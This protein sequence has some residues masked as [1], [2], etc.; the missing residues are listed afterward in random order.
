MFLQRYQK[1]LSKRDASGSVVFDDPAGKSPGGYE[2]RTLLLRQ[3]NSLK[4][5]GCPYTN[6]TFSNVGPITFSDSKATTFI[7]IADLIAYNTFRQ[8]RTHGKEWEDLT[9][10]AFPMY[11]H[12]RSVVH[13]FDLGPRRRLDGF[14]IAKWPVGN[15]VA[16]LL[17]TV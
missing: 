12:F 14:G 17:P 15:R 16:R 8:F 5:N 9:I 11:E 6:T 13:L 2:W 4:K 10:S 1:Y 3:H 7:Q